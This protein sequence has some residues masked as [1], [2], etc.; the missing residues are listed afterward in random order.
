MYVFPFPKQKSRPDAVGA[1]PFLKAVFSD[2]SRLPVAFQYAV[3]LP[4]VRALSFPA[5]AA[6]KK[7]SPC[8]RIL[9]RRHGLSCKR[10]DEHRLPCRRSGKTA[11]LP[12]PGHFLRL[13]S[14]PR[15]PFHTM[16]PP[17]SFPFSRRVRPQ[18]PPCPCPASR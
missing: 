2:S 17:G 4:P 15:R 8:C 11:C 7:Y 18:E 5:E 16:M 6:R 1:A 3:P 12:F 13:C 14:F 10:I 9:R